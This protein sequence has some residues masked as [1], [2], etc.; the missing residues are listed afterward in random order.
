MERHH[1]GPSHGHGRGHHRHRGHHPAVGHARHEAAVG[2]RVRP[3]LAYSAIT[4]TNRSP[5]TWPDWPTCRS[6]RSRASFSE[7]P[8]DAATLFAQAAPAHGQ[9]ALVYRSSAGEGA[10]LTAASPIRV[11]FPA[12]SVATLVARPGL[13]GALPLGAAAAAPGTI[14]AALYNFLRLLHRYPAVLEPGGLS[15]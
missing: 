5:I 2:D 6:G 7:L 1:Q 9:P 13:S 8:C 15:S 3:G 14:P 4:T 11:T 10:R 12:N